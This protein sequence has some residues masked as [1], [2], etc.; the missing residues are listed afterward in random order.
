MKDQFRTTTP[1]WPT[2]RQGVQ[3]A[4]ISITLLRKAA[5][6]ILSPPVTR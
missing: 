6:M 2:G 3:E 4:Y 5:R 1:V